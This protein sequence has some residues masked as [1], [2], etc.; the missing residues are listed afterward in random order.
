MVQIREKDLE[1]RPL[2]DLVQHLM[3]LIKRHQGNVFVND[4]IDLV[5]ALGA[6][7]VHLRTDS[8]PV[9]LAR[10]LLGTGHLI[11]TST[12]SVEEVRKAEVRV[13]T[14]SCLVRFL[15]H[16]RSECMGHL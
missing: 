15:R 2:I 7:G 16:L 1:T 14:S 12:H 8:L 3:P 10:R 9:S 4:R 11:G 5:L 13:Q 6:D